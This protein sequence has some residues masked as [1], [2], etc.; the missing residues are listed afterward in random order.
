MKTRLRLTTLFL[1]LSLVLST[2]PVSVQAAPPI[3]SSFYGEVKIDGANVPDGTSVRAWINGTPY[4]QTTTTT[5]GGASVYVL[6]VPGDDPDTPNAVEGGASGDTITFTIDEQTATPTA[7]WQ[8]GTNVAHNLSRTSAPPIGIAL[9]TNAAANIGAQVTIP[10]SVADSLTG[11][12][13]LAYQFTLTYDPSV[14]QF[15]GIDKSGTLSA[16]FDVLYNETTPG[17]VLFA[18]AGG[19]YLSGSGVLLKFTFSVLTDSGG[20]TSA[21]TLSNFLLNGGSPP[22]QTTNGSFTANP[23]TIT[24]SISY[25][26]SGGPVSG[27]TVDSS[28]PHNSSATTNASGA[29]TLN[30]NETGNYTVVPAKQ[31]DTRS[32]ISAVDATNVLQYL[33]ATISLTADQQ[34]A[35]DVNQDGAVQAWDAGHIARFVA[36]LDNIASTGT[37]KFAPQN[38]SYANLNSN[39]TGQNYGAYLYGDVSGNWGS[40][41]RS[42]LVNSS[43][44]TLS[45]SSLVVIPNQEFE[46]PIEITTNDNTI[47]GYQVRLTF[48]SDVLELRAIDK[49]GSLSE[50][51]PVVVNDTVAG[52]LILVGYTSKPFST[53]GTLLNLRFAVV[54]EIGDGSD[55]RLKYVRIN[56]YPA[57][58]EFDAGVG[59][60]MIGPYRLFLPRLSQ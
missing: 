9:P 34:I 12:N 6:N 5:S 11:L 57:V 48:D 42:K 60:L 16:N 23:L 32:A 33:T 53:N 39:Q 31:G 49:M 20:A 41:A 24:G 45:L 56:E 35:A 15:T 27:V 14:L 4:A 38:R 37:W 13:I 1:L 22:A 3:P 55:V 44:P 19:N 47:L 30:V 58:E 28:G 46:M 7:T 43:F 51:W 17:T 59:H 40:V 25:T 50:E 8:S 10:L 26:F 54:G 2:A 36:G 21:L 18:A 52:E 29:Y